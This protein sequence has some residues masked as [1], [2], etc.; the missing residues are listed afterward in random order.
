[1]L[2]LVVPKRSVVAA[3]RGV[4]ALAHL[5]RAHIFGAPPARRRSSA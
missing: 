3:A 5:V 2:L 1:L 4:G